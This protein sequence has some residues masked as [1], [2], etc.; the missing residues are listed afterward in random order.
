MKKKIIWISV[1]LVVVAIIAVYFLAPMKAWSE[2]RELVKNTQ[3]K[4]EGSISDISYVSFC[5]SWWKNKFIGKV[6]L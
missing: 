3:T 5:G 2:Y 4:L 6:M 1:A